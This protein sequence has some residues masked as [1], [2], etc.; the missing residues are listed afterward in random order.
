MITQIGKEDIAKRVEELGKQISSNYDEL[1]VIGLLNGSFIFMA[2]LVRC[3][4]I[5]VYIDFIR[6][7]SYIN[8]QRSVIKLSSSN[9]I[10]IRDKDV[11]VVDD[12]IDSGHSLQYITNLLNNQHPKSVK[13]CCLLDKRNNRSCDIDADYVG[14]I[15][16]DNDFVFGYGLDYDGRYRNLDHI[17]VK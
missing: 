6:I 5:P 17:A 15:L 16:E 14:F 9:S 12:I 4:S 1:V 3:I 7:Q 13:T 8:N 10:Q 11:L 2:D